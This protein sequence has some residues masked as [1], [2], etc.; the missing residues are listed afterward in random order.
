MKNIFIFL[1]SLFCFFA[2]SQSNSSLTKKNENQYLL[3][4]GDYYSSNGQEEKAIKLYSENEK[5]LTANQ[6]RILSKFLQNKGDIS[7]AAKVLK[8]LLETKKVS[9]LDYYNYASLISDN[10]KLSDEYIEKATELKIES[11]FKKNLKSTNDSYKLKNLNMN[12]DKSEFGAI[13]LDSNDPMF[14]FLGNQRQRIKNLTTENQVYNIF[15]ANFDFDSLNTSGISELDLRFNSKYQDGP[16]AL[17]RINKIL[18][19][20]RSSNKIDK[21]KEVQ[22]DLYQLPFEDI[23]KKMPIPLSI[24]IDGY[25]TLHPSVSPDGKRLYFASDRPNGFGGMDLYYVALEKGVISGQIQN[26]GKDINT[27]EDEVFPFLYDNDILFYS[28]RSTNKKLKLMIA[29]NRFANRWE[30][31]VLEKPFNS[32]GDD[33]SLSI[34]KKYKTGFISSNRKGGKG[35]DDIYSFKFIP[36]LKGENDKYEFKKN[37]TLVVGFNNVLK[38]DLDLMFSEDPL[39][40]II[41]LEAKLVQG[42][43]KGN[44]IFNSNGSF[45]YVQD[46]D[47]KG[48]DFFTYQITGSGINS[49]NIIV[50]LV[51]RKIDFKGVFRP[52]YYKFDKSN[53][54]IDYKQ[55]LD[56][57]VISLNE[58]PDLNL[59]ISSYADCRGSSI[60]NLKLTEERNQTILNYLKSKIF[61]PKRISTIAFGESQIQNNPGYE[62]AIVISSSK[63]KKNAII[64]LEKFEKLKKEVIIEQTEKNFHVLAGKYQSYRE[65][66]KYLNDLNQMGYKGWIKKSHCYQSLESIHQSNRK[67]TFK[68]TLN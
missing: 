12:S 9:V 68:V 24:N 18:Y 31:K 47:K 16:L 66:R 22:L 57:L 10:K 17:D 2:K 39:I 38:N 6:R 1:I 44:L 5:D 4:W 34:N 36:N 26:L 32:E 27:S 29:L 15:K 11:N 8:P 65:A 50:E 63:S 60:Y 59:E 23:E 67:T 7:Q 20:T 41:P 14:Y 19:L 3:K 56:S 35:D 49:E 55:R 64:S 46:S 42:T 45:L 21:N 53:L 52:I 40:E 54:E 61:N 13:I 25:S 48:N 43:S 37:D 58:Y 51:P 30:S 28:S 33:F 62:Y